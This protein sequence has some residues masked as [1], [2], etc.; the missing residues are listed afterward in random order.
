MFAGNRLAGNR[1]SL[2]AKAGLTGAAVFTAVLAL[3]APASAAP[4][5]AGVAVTP[6]TGLSDGARV[7]VDVTD[8]GAGEAV[9]VSECA[10]TPGT[11]SLVCDVAGIKQVTTDAAGAGSTT[12]TVKKTFQGQDQSGNPVT[13]DC[14][15]VAGGCFIGASDQAQAYATAAISFS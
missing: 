4:A 3:S 6:S 7:A 14:A 2:I 15:T 1:T 10:G 11:A 8:F 9:S 5:A 12:T 13:V